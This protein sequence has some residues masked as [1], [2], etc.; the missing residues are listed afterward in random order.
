MPIFVYPN[1]HM[2]TK[3]MLYMHFLRMIIH[4]HH[5]P[6]LYMTLCLST[7]TANTKHL[8]NICTTSARRLRG[9][10]NIVQMLYKCFVFTGIISEMHNRQLYLLCVWYSLHLKWSPPE[11]KI[12]RSSIVL[13]FA[14]QISIGSTSSNSSDWEINCCPNSHIEVNIYF[15]MLQNRV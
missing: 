5:R 4:L 3:C 9:W 12:R 6:T 15:Q 8:Y 10:S 7:I 1:K 13:M 2:I 11:D 14:H